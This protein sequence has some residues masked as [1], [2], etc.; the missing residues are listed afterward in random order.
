[1]R[2]LSV[3]LFALTLSVSAFSQT[4]D[5]KKN[6]TSDLINR[7]GDHFMIQ[8]AQNMWTGTPDSIDGHIKGFNRSANVYLMLNKPFRNNEK[9]SVALGIGIG[10]SNIYFKNMNVNIASLTSPLP[11][12]AT[13]SSNHYKKYKLSTTFLEVP[14]EFRYTARPETPNKGFK[15]AIGLKVGT[16]LNAHTKGKEL[17]SKTGTTVSNSVDKVSTKS[18]FTSTRLAATARVGYGI[19]SL[20]GAYNLTPVFKDGV[21]EDIK[22]FQLG[23]TISGL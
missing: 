9:L 7:A 12:V 17:I 22:L 19:F 3:A 15:A 14:V 5:K 21:A 11:F 23:L 8:L 10:N 6:T 4:T 18:F 16:L 13:D 1:M 2:K 20:F